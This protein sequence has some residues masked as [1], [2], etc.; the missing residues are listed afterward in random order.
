MKS[1]KKT[2]NDFGGIMYST[3]PGF[4]FE[5]A[6]ESTEQIPNSQQDLRVTLDK[7]N[8]G[9]KVVTLVL[10]FKG[11]DSALEALAKSLKSKCGVGGGSKNGEVFLQGDFR[12]KVLG[13]LQSEG[14][15]AKRSGG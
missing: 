2:I 6:G 5:E 11:P 4:Q 12:D 13:F 8:R 1:K 9:G 3:D 7:K 14:Y 15:K 10:G